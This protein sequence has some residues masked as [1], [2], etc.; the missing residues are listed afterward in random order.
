MSG[1]AGWGKRGQSAMRDCVHSAHGVR[2][3]AG[4]ASCV[5][6][7]CATAVSQRWGVRGSVFRPSNVRM[8]RNE[9]G[10]W[11]G[12]RKIRGVAW[13]LQSGSRFDGWQV[14]TQSKKLLVL[15]ASSGRG[16]QPHGTGTEADC[17]RII[18]FFTSLPIV[19]STV[20]YTWRFDGAFADTRRAGE[21]GVEVRA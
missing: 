7:A 11:Q 15:A 14:S 21:A 8:R 16:G 10:P 5:V 19:P 9:L 13:S 17:P 18:R 4:R 1:S 12:I 3:E 6:S 20:L 2:N